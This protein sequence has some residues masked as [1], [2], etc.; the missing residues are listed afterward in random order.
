MRGQ[1]AALGS[2]APA[3]SRGRLRG[4]GPLSRPRPV[5]LALAASCARGGRADE[6]VCSADEDVPQRVKAIT[7]AAPRD[8]CL[9]LRIIYFFNFVCEYC[10]L[11][12]VRG[13]MAAAS[14]VDCMTSCS[15]CL[16]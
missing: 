14:C 6:V 1:H 4:P 9:M 15:I 7:G 5:L 8:Y 12:A 2:G 13:S 10:V 16:Q 3:L 11:C